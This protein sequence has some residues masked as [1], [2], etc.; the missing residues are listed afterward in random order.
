[1]FVIMF[2]VNVVLMVI[3]LV[4]NPEMI[5]HYG[6]DIFVFETATTS[7]QKNCVFISHI[8]YVV[9]D[10][11]VLQQSCVLSKWRGIS[12]SKTDT[13][14]CILMYEPYR[15]SGHISLSLKK[16]GVKGRHFA[17]VEIYLLIEGIPAWANVLLH[18]DCIHYHLV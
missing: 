2:V 4:I 13:E 6:G 5:C 8:R 1:M 12:N 17:I 9:Q 10:L 7:G 16:V 14:W 15:S 18:K 3:V 11:T